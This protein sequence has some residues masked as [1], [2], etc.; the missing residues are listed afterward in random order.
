MHLAL[1][2]VGGRSGIA[3]GAGHFVG[4]GD[5]LVEGGGHQLH[6]LA[7]AA[8]GVVHVAGHAGAG[9]RGSLQIRRGAANALHQGAD[10]AQ[11]LVE[12]ARQQGG[13]VV[14]AHIQAAGQ[15]AFALGDALQAAGHAA[16]RLDDQ[17]GEAGA[18]DGEQHRQHR[19]DHADLPGQAGGLGHH[20]AALDQ[21]NEAPAQ[22]FRRPD[23]GHVGHPTKL[24]LDQAVLDAGQFRV[25]VAQLADQLEVMFRGARV[26][27]HVAVA[28]EQHQ[29]AAFTQLDLLDQFG[30]LLERHV[31]AHH[32]GRLALLVID[33]AHGAHQH[34]VIG[35][36]VVGGG[37]HGFARCGHGGLVPGAYTRV[38]AA[39]LGIIRPGGVAAVGLA[40]R[41][42]GSARV[43]GGELAEHLQERLA[44]VG[45]RNLRCVGACVVLQLASVAHRGMLGQVFDVLG[46]G[47]EELVHGV[48][49][50]PDLAAAAV[51]EVIPRLFAQVDHHHDGD[52]N[53]GHTGNGREGPGEFLFD[54]HGGSCRVVK[55]FC[56]VF[57]A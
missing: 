31:Q 45:L 6:G 25:A 15:V 51:Q 43:A 10:G 30:E 14:A 17:P 46:D 49:D 29:V 12:P 26:D 5:H 2:G 42:V 20:F 1:A 47:V 33:G 50:L 8:C 34:H 53:D 13:F 22:G 24:H 38:I 56:W 37:A 4:G 19:G 55:R 48:F 7:L 52:Q 11:E 18:D 41:Q 32:S 36:P 27:Q 54:V 16:D 57:T 9:V 21:A 28:L 39:Q 23:I 3:A 40:Q 35:R 44:R